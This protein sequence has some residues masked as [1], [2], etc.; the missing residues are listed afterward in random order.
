MIKFKFFYVLIFCLSLLYLYN[1]FFT[2]YNITGV[3]INRNFE[4]SPIMPNFH[5]KLILKSDGTC[6]SSY[7]GN[8]KYFIEYNL[9]GTEITI[10]SDNDYIKT[11]ITRNWYTSPKIIIFRDLNHYYEKK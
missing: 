11:Y 1:N 9:K 7:F 4:E 2:T 3:Y 6:Y 10:K 8:G 5:D